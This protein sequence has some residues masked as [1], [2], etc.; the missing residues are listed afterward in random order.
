MKYAIAFVLSLLTT[1]AA[2]EDIIGTVTSVYDGDTL[3]L[4]TESDVIKVRL[5]DIDAPERKQPHG[6]AARQ[7]LTALAHGKTAQI[8]VET[9]D[10]YGRTVG[11]VTVNGVDVNAEMVRQ[12]AAWVY[13]KYSH[14][15]ALLLLESEAK[16]AQRGLWSL[17][18]A[19]PPW[20]WRK[21][22]RSHLL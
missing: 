13:R 17:S 1:I 10:R 20:E 8:K 18:D 12:G 6:D 19:M 3:T 5:A 11:R 21:A 22:K 15:A 9:R 2:A 16:A 7:V 14:D 4:T